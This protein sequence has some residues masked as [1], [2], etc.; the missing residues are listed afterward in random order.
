MFLESLEVQK[1]KGEAEKETTRQ[2]YCLKSSPKTALSFFLT[3]KN[4]FIL[5]TKLLV[6]SLEQHYL[7]N[8]FNNE[9]ARG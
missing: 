3:E 5:T 9:K 2:K 7:G 4:H 8:V 1:Y 6:R